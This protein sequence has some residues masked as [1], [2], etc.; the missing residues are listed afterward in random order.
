M[1]HKIL[2]P[3]DGSTFGER[4]IP[5]AL[6]VAGHVGAVVELA[7]VHTPPF[8]EG[9][10]AP[11]SDPRFDLEI[12]HGMRTALD[13]VHAR[14]AAGAGVTVTPCFLVGEVVPTLQAHVEADGIDL[15][16]MTTHGRGGVSRAWMGNIADALV[17]HLHVPVLLARSRK[18]GRGTGDVPPFRRTL[19]PLDGSLRAEGIL[20]H[21]IALGAA[22]QS[23]YLLLRVV[24]PYPLMPIIYPGGGIPVDPGALA[25]QEQEAERYLAGV[26]EQVRSAGLQVS[27]RVL[28]HDQPARAILESVR[29]WNADLVAI[30]SHGQGAIGR[31]VFGSV[32]DKIV[33]GTTAPTLVHHATA[34]A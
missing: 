31:L 34:A 28:V 16:V 14:V 33:R 27:T 5:L 21:A 4:A 30:T 18:V 23:Q 3:L 24:A 6:R 11:M 26:A 15:V 7:H 22:K 2:V 17:R 8:R 10:G 19:V 13:R 9:G 20:A 32:A 1:Y 25:R 12:Q 29:E